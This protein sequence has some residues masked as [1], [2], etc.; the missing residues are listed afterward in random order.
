MLSPFPPMFTYASGGGGGGAGTGTRTDRVA[1]AHHMFGWPY[2]LVS[3]AHHQ[4]NSTLL[5]VFD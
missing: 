4:I 1:D 2:S 5:V 3:V